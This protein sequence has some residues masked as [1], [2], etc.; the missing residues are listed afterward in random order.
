MGLPS[1]IR[2]PTVGVHLLAPSPSRH[3]CAGLSLSNHPGVAIPA[4]KVT[5]APGGAGR[6]QSGRDRCRDEQAERM[7]RRVGS[8]HAIID[9]EDVADY[10]QIPSEQG[11]VKRRS[12]D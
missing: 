2:T 11:P 4:A 1:R 6:G 10:A 9:N 12:E 5:A 3:E 8:T 7:P